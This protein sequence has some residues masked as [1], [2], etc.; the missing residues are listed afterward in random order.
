MDFT[1]DLTDEEFKIY[2]THWL[3]EEVEDYEDTLPEEFFIEE[4]K[5][6]LD[7][8]ICNQIR[9]R[10]DVNNRSAGELHAMWK[11]LEVYNGAKEG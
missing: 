2:K 3:D 10:M 5:R 11:A 9:R 1:F 7:K 4:L 8:L 6:V